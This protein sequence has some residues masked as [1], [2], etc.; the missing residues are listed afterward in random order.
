MQQK[1]GGHRRAATAAS[2]APSRAPVIVMPSPRLVRIVT[3]AI[4]FLTAIR[5]LLIP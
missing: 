3:I 1:P 2:R 5:L 4:G